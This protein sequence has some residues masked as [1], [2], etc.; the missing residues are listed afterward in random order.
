MH[1]LKLVIDGIESKPGPLFAIKR[2]AKRTFYRG[3]IKYGDKAV[4]QRATKV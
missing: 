4:I 1:L 2:M 3:N